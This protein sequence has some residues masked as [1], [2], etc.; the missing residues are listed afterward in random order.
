MTHEN[1]IGRLVKV[2]NT[3]F[4]NAA[5]LDLDIVARIMLS[6]RTSACH[7]QGRVGDKFTYSV[8]IMQIEVLCKA[9]AKTVTRVK[10]PWNT[11]L[12][13]STVNTENANTRTK[14]KVTYTSANSYIL[15]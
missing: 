6:R 2:R 11:G 1:D 10:R 3:C 8:C 14:L 12:L 15:S 4:A 5:Y 13:D 7:W 9:G